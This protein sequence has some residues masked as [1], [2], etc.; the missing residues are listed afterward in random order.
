MT[1]LRPIND[2][3]VITWILY[4]KI[5]S[6]EKTGDKTGSNTCRSRLEL[7]RSQ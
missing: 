7:K 3:L 2:R 6:L 1:D 4:V 5:S